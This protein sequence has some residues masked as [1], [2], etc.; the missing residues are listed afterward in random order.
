MALLTGLEVQI[1]YAWDD[2]EGQ[3]QIVIVEGEI[4]KLSLEEAGYRY[5]TMAERNSSSCCVGLC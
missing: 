3:E 5:G 4:D 1:L 2:I